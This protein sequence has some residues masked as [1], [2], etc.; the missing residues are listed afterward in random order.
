MSDLKEDLDRALRTVTFSE[1]PVE[2]A[3]R[4]GRRIRA[5]RRLSVLA[6]ALAVAAVAAGYPAL[7]R[8]AAAPPAPA[9]GG[10][11]TPKA[12]HDPVVTAYPAPHATQ[13]PGGLT[14]TNGQV[15]AGTIGKQKW[16]ASIQAA[17]TAHAEYCFIFTPSPAGDSGQQ[18]DPVPDLKSAD[19]SGTAPAVFDGIG[20]GTTSDLMIG[21]AAADVTYFIVTFKDAQQLK[22]IPVSAGGHRYFA[23]AAPASMMIESVDAYLG[24]PYSTSGVIAT[25]VPFAQPGQLPVI[26]LWHGAPGMPTVPQ[27]ETK[28]ITGTTAGHPWKVTVYAGPWGIC[29]VGSPGGTQCLPAVRITVT[30]VAGGSGGDQAGAN[31][32]FAAPGTARVRVTLSDGTTVTAPTVKVGVELVFAFW[33]GK[34][35]SPTA[36]TTYDASGRQTGAGASVS[37]SATKSASP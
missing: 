32:G 21:E 24:G 30:Y 31:W 22:L 15:G 37:I 14:S 17:G 2:A 19:P 9:I 1:A 7:T 11:P 5:R 28:A 36:W 4:G 23:W 16:Q 6:G 12:T 33:A 20:G 34:N 18:C 8:T 35:V 27:R 25:A 29:A 13:A 10:S 26:G 3:K